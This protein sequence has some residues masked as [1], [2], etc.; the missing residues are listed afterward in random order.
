[1]GRIN[2]MGHKTAQVN[3]LF[4]YWSCAKTCSE[5]LLVWM[6]EAPLSC[7]DPAS[8][9]YFHKCSQW[10]EMSPAQRRHC[11]LLT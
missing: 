5:N 11:L 8:R 2:V 4:S 7:V 9:P 10:A 1:M 6:E 3:W